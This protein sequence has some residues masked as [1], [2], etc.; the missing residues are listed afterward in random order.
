[1]TVRD[2]GGASFCANKVWYVHFDQELK[3][4]AGKHAATDDPLL[5]TQESYELSYQTLYKL[6]PNCRNC[7]C[8]PW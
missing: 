5:R 4:L 1:M 7:I 3:K 2:E 6:L 8:V